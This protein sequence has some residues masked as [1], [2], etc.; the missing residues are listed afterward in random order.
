MI[1]IY[2]TKAAQISPLN[3]QWEELKAMAKGYLIA[4]NGIYKLFLGCW[5]YV[6]EYFTVPSNVADKIKEVTDVANFKNV[7]LLP[8][9]QSISSSHN[10][11]GY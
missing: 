7:H 3:S 2:K 4:I 8:S 11:Q 1:L 6:K 5:C 10:D 9:L